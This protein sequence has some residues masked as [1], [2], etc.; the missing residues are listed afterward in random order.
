MQWMDLISNDLMV[1]HVDPWG[2]YRRQRIVSGSVVQ[3]RID[4]VLDSIDIVLSGSV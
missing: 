1:R 4:F 3:G 2:L